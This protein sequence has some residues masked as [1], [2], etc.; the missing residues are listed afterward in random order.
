MNKIAVILINYCNY[1]L[2]CECI[3]SIKE[4]TYD[5]YMIVVVD[6]ASPDNSGNKLENYK[7]IKFVQMKQNVGFAAGNNIGIKVALE[8]NCEYV[9]LLNNDT[10]IDSRMIESL[11]KNAN[12]NTVVVP[13]MYYFDLN[14]KK[15]ILWYAGGEIKY[16]SADGLHWEGG[17]KDSDQFSIQ[18]Q[19]SFATGCC[20]LIHKN[21]LK[22]VGLFREE[23]FMYCEDTDYS[24][25]LNKQNIDIIYVP[26][27]KLWHKVSSSSGGEMSKFI[28][29][30]VV[31]N[32]IYC[33][34][35]NK[36]G[37]KTYIYIIAETFYRTLKAKSGKYY[38][39]Y[40]IAPK[41]LVHGLQK[42]M[43]KNDDK[44]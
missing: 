10:I 22:K 32:K 28:V 1:E 15:D 2:T 24:I 25:R 20:M 18:K 14:G 7:G 12:E 41:A 39:N 21:I 35:V 6:N 38:S 9:L 13:K 4:S 17:K 33:A 31:R 19:V 26:D 37:I 16:K 44:L 5:N 42:K 29:Y 30:Y 40:L 43:G 34:I 23:Y 11:L 36:L 27:A 8:H 3:E